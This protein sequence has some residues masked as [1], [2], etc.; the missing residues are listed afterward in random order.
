V[1][2]GQRLK[3]R[4]HLTGKGM[5]IGALNLPFP[6]PLG[7]EVLY[8]DVLTPEQVRARY[9]GSRVPDIVSDSESYPSIADH[10]FDFIIAN[11]I[12]EHVTDPIRAL[13]EWYRTLKSGGILY[14]TLPD[15]RF[16]FD[17]GR[18]RTPLSHLIEDH[19][20]PLP[21]RERNLGHLKE[22][23]TFVEGLEP[24]SEA[25]KRFVDYEYAKGY[26]VHNH[27]WILEDILELLSYLD[28]EGVAFDWIDG[29]DT[30]PEDLEFILILRKNAHARRSDPKRRFRFQ[31]RRV[32]TLAEG[33][34]RRFTGE[35]YYGARRQLK[36]VLTAARL[37][38]GARQSPTS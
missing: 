17:R 23:A 15:K 4:H 26:S 22:W 38:P 25:W 10:T 1:N 32:R 3:Y 12:L 34:A 24:E 28:R 9:P 18:P 30:H 6:V 37:I 14:L 19:H 11:H 16:T 27:V 13:R 29:T 36:R 2:H 5:E 35:V 33:R 20:S 31:V 21:P 7:V 8:S